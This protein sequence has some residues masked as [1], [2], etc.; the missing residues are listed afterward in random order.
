MGITSPL[1]TWAL[2]DGG[3]SGQFSRDRSRDHLSGWFGND[4]TENIS[5]SGDTTTPTS[6]LSE[7]LPA[8]Y[9][10]SPSGVGASAG[11]SDFYSGGADLPPWLSSAAGTAVGALGAYAGL[12]SPL[13]NAG[14]KLLSIG[15]GSEGVNPHTLLNGGIDLG[16]S[17]LGLGLPS[18]VAK[19]GAKVLGY[20][21]DPANAIGRATNNYYIQSPRDLN[22]QSLMNNDSSDAYTGLNQPTMAE[23]TR[24]EEQNRLEH[25][26]RGTADQ[27]YADQEA[28]TIA[29]AAQAQA[30]EAAKEQAQ[31]AIME[32]TRQSALNQ[33]AQQVTANSSSMASAN[34]ASGG[35]TGA[36][37]NSSGLVGPGSAY[38]NSPSSSSS[39]YSGGNNYTSSTGY[40]NS[41]TGPGSYSGGYSGNRSND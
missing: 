41:N 3:R 35:A 22:L 5:H 30:E 12:P 1:Q 25:A 2:M 38:V 6:A 27:Y 34:P 24:Q 26:A 32:Q 23:I 18:M 36:T 17:L 39:S 8:N 21:Y 19:L 20:D 4:G 14:G 9:S 28:Q 13:V 37:P 10:S 40:G 11:D 29:R 33:L 16:A 31:A 7:A 15:L